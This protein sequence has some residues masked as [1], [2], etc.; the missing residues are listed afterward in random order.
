MSH[1]N[2]DVSYS[3]TPPGNGKKSTRERNLR[4]RASRKA[5]KSASIAPERPN[6]SAIPVI[7]PMRLREEVPSVASSSPVPRAMANKNKRK[8]FLKAMDGA[9]GKRIVYPDSVGDVVPMQYPCLATTPTEQS[10]TSERK[11]TTTQPLATGLDGAA[12]SS[13]SPMRLPPLPPSRMNTLSP[14]LI[15][16]SKWFTIPSRQEAMKEIKKE[17]Q[18]LA[19]A[20]SELKPHQTEPVVSVDLASP[21]GWNESVKKFEHFVV[22]TTEN[23]GKLQEHDLVAWKVCPNAC[24]PERYI[25]SNADLH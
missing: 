4:R 22:I 20:R 19:A 9:I 12:F 16:K 14:N 2:D 7:S 5:Q 21:S 17:A 10:S 8:G 1:R 13:G 6:P 23:A 24:L 3:A 18:L 15:V 11:S 25:M